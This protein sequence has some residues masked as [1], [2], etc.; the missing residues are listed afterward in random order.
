[1]DSN[2]HRR[3]AASYFNFRLRVAKT[4]VSG[5]LWKPHGER[6]HGLWISEAT[7]APSR[8]DSYGQLHTLLVPPFVV[9][10]SLSA[11]L[12]KNKPHAK[13]H[14]T[15]ECRKPAD[16][17]ISIITITILSLLHSHTQSAK[18]SCKG[19]PLQS[20]IEERFFMSP[21]LQARKTLQTLKVDCLLY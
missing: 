15:P 8:K 13:D 11:T 4:E 1:M 16:C 18:A 10:V 21:R 7:E 14:G 3:L 17:S 12:T 9:M 6:N 2:L 19:H 20:T 5:E